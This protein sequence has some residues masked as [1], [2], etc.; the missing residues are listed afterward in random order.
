MAVH[1][2]CGLHSCIP[3][4]GVKYPPLRIQNQPVN[5]I[6]QPPPI[7]MRVATHI[8]GLSCLPKEKTTVAFP[9]PPLKKKK[10][11]SSPQTLSFVSISNLFSNLSFFF[12]QQSNFPK[13]KTY[14]LY[15][16]KNSDFSNNILIL[17]F[18]TYFQ[19]ISFF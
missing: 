17:Q 5:N 16:K 10:K 6:S 12:F 19:L 7:L 13:F 4:L 2:D 1:G 8:W 9:Q 11:P 14:P 3:S 18:K 15:F